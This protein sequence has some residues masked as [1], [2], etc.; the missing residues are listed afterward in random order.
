VLFERRKAQ[1]RAI[2]EHPFH[3][4]KNLFGYKQGEL[5]RTA[6]ERRPPVCA[7]RLGQPRAV[8]AC[9]T[10]WPTPRHWYVLKAQRAPNEHELRLESGSAVANAPVLLASRNPTAVGIQRLLDDALFSTSLTFELSR[11]QRRGAW[12]ARGRIDHQRLAGQVSC[13]CASALE[14]GVRPHPPPR[15][16]PT[17]S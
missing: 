8:Q 16:N 14:R 13:R 12:P 5:P 11:A 4:I 1:I 15:L 6:Q 7:V 9:T 10:G 2:V 3:V 17:T